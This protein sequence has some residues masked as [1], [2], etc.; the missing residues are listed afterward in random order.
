MAVCTYG[1]VPCT[2]EMETE[3]EPET[4]TDT[5]PE[6]ET[7]TEVTPESDWA[8]ANVLRLVAD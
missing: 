8:R 2:T 4:E 5:K 3:T 7:E 1:A 6:T